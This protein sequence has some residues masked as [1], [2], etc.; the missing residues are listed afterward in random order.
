MVETIWEQNINNQK[1]KE[2]QNE[3]EKLKSL[4]HDIFYSRSE[5]RIDLYLKIKELLNIQLGIL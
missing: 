4:L 5:I 2:L 1:V 3:N